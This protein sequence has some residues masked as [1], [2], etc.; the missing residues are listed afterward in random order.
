MNILNFN[1]STLDHSHILHFTVRFPLPK[2]S[3]SQIYG[4]C[5]KFK[6]NTADKENSKHEKSFYDVEISSK[7]S[8]RSS[9]SSYI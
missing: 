6:I 4:H 8:K 9:V 3:K 7:F 1:T 5:V 2:T